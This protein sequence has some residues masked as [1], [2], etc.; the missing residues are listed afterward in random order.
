MA[1]CK[2]KFLSKPC[3]AVLSDVAVQTWVCRDDGQ[4][5]C[6]QRDQQSAHTHGLFR[7]IVLTKPM[8]K[9]EFA[10]KWVKIGCPIV[11]KECVYLV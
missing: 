4:H 9:L 7:Q 11:F 3:Q 5:A 1:P 6:C 2:V 10:P 8:R